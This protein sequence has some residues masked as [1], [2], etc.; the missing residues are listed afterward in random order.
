LQLGTKQI[1]ELALKS[2]TGKRLTARLEGIAAE[3]PE[4]QQNSLSPQL[5]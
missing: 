2:A 5:Q 4:T 3:D 1:G